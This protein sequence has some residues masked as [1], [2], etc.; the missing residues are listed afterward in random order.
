ETRWKRCALA[1]EADDVEADERAGGSLLVG[2][3]LIEDGDPV[4]LLQARPVRHLQRHLLVI[5]ENGDR[6]HLGAL[7]A[8]CALC[9]APDKPHVYIARAGS[10]IAERRVWS[11]FSFSRR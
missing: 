11:G 1:H 7:P 3:G 9:F 4:V 2:E 8:D 10:A 6:D 5:I